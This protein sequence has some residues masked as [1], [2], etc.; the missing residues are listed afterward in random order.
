MRKMNFSSSNQQLRGRADPGG[1]PGWEPH[2]HP[3]FIAVITGIRSF[4]LGLAL[5]ES[6]NTC[7]LTSAPQVFV[8]QFLL[9][10]S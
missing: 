7:V 4:L 1:C 10:P 9:F 2:P 8:M 5:A 3:V 6:P